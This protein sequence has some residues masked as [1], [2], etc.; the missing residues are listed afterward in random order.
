M[1]NLEDDLAR[2]TRRIE[3][4]GHRARR[5]LE[6]CR[7][8][9]EGL[10]AQG[11]QAAGVGDAKGAAEFE[12]RVQKIRGRSRRYEDLVA[13][14]D[15]GGGKLAAE[16]LLARLQGPEV[17]QLAGEVE[18]NRELIVQ[19]ATAL[20]RARD[21]H[22]ALRHRWT[23]LADKIRALRQGR[24]LPEARGALPV[25]FRINVTPA[26][27]VQQPDGPTY[28]EVSDVIHQIGG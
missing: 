3:E 9:A 2:E 12:R 7:R 6:E 22:R 20:L 4:L 5:R 10:V 1:S 25:D 27:Y 8:E 18:R 14:F 15:S 21:R 28:R 24:G 17:D 16:V 19:R 11:T 26:T 13:E 23:E